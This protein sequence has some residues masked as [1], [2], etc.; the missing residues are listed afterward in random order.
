MNR[1]LTTSKR[2]E[3]REKVVK[4]PY[5]T[6]VAGVLGGNRLVGAEEVVKVSKLPELAVLQAQVVGLLEGSGR[7]LVNILAQAGGGGLVRTLEGL[8]KNLGEEVG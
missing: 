7:N 6:L 3:S 4:Q 1:S 2:P 8:Q 5:M